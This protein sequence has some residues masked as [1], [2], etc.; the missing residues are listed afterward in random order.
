MSSKEKQ[1][2]N[3]TKDSVSLL[4]CFYFVELPILVSAVVSLYFLELTDL[5]KPARL[6]YCCHDRSLS[7]PYIE[8][9]QEVIPLLMLLSLVLA[10]PTITIMVG[11]GI[12]Y[13]GLSR[14][15]KGFGAEADINAA[16]CN[17]NSF[18]RRAVRFIGVHVFGLCAT[19]LITDILQ[20]ATGYHT[21]Y[22]L[23]VCKPNYTTLN[24]PCDD[25]TY[26]LQNICT[27]VETAAIN[28]GRKSFP[29][30]HATLA[31]FAAVYISMYFNST[32]TDSSKLLKPLL[33][34][35]FII[36]AI[37]CGMTRIIQYKNHAI[38]VYLGFL[39]GG[40]VAVY[41]GLYAVGNFEPGVQTCSCAPSQAC[42][43]CPLPH[44]GR[45]ALRHLQMKSTDGLSTSHSESIVHH[46][47]QHRDASSGSLGSLKRSSAEVVITSPHS[48]M[49]KDS[50]VT[51][52]HTLPRVHTPAMDDAMRRNATIHHS[53]HA[54]MDSSRSKQ[55]LSQW[56]NKNQE[57]RKYS[58]QGADGEASLFQSPHHPGGIGSEPSVIG[59]NGV[60]LPTQYVKLATG[61]SSTLLRDCSGIT[62]GT[63]VSMQSR[64]G[65]SQLV[66]IPEETQENFNNPL[67]RTGGGDH[68]NA[69]HAN[70]AKAAENA[71]VP[72]RTNDGNQQPRIMQVIA[73]SK[74]QGLLQ[75][76]SKSF[77]EGCADS[78]GV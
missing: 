24:T 8:P 64:P 15:T 26:I 55:L 20:L 48:P 69:L 47:L 16:G 29:S 10:G 70:W 13:C 46:N 62:G 35:S 68:G 14:K 61:G 72:C 51:F 58:V 66:H 65:S 32:L 9:N 23:T 3:M 19:A 28:Q 42:S 49:G 2:G 40:G 41:L 33:V 7:L 18:I 77:D 27:G 38:D 4:P 54:T 56:K 5:F 45:D 76:H 78:Y 74:Q 39:L 59:I 44:L 36:C 31:S 6:G 37:I 43:P 53:H 17:F 30:Q 57:S 75:G 73:L 34:F 52:S 21:P 11:E 71:A 50:M 1:K 60:D 67:P 63:R 12:L 25:N 22:F